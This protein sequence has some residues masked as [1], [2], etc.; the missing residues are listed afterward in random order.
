ME[1]EPTKCPYLEICKCPGGK[2]W[3]PIKGF[4]REKEGVLCLDWG[5]TIPFSDIP[6]L[7][8][9]GGRHI[10]DA[11]VAAD[12]IDAAIRKYNKSIKRRNAQRR[13]EGTE[14]GKATI[15]KYQDSEKFKLSQQK[16]YHS[17][18]GQKAHKKRRAVVKDFRDAEKWLK[19]HPGSSYKDYLKEQQN[20][21]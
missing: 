8:T 13:F 7:R 3:E 12:K 5:K 6:Q 21:T 9:P 2:D 16:Y 20:D 11:V 15:E 1:G 4:I 19:E 18:K 17:K 14:G 10:S